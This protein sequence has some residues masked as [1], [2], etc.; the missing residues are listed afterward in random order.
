MLAAVP[1]AGPHAQDVG[2]GTEAAG[3]HGLEPERAQGPWPPPETPPTR[4][5]S[6]TAL[7]AQK[8]YLQSKG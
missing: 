2:A 8:N 3:E 6:G 7:D 4:P 5:T 1:V